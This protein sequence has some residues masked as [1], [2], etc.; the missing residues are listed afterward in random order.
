MSFKFYEDEPFP[1]LYSADEEKKI[2][3]VLSTGDAKKARYDLIEHN[4]RLVIYIASGLSDDPAGED[5]LIS[6][7]VIGLIKAVDTFDPDR[8]VRLCTYA[9][10]C[11]KN[12]IFSYMR[13]K[14]KT[15]REIPFEEIC[16]TE[17]S[18]NEKYP[19]EFFTDG[20]DPVAD[21]IEEDN[22]KSSLREA[23]ERLDAKER[24]FIEM[25]YGLRDE[26]GSYMT[27]TEIARSTG[28]SQA[29]LSKYEKKIIEHLKKEMTGYELS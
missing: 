6:V 5:D 9:A 20:A 27:Q 3:S 25:R 16:G 11:I 24:D 29:Y 28:V 18:G 8:N 7:G 2:L 23:L 1:A 22:E 13:N 17:Q 15:L 10:H 21:L 19:A 14:L 12:E 4:L 26:S